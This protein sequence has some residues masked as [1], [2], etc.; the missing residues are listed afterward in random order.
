MT[1][2]VR[3]RNKG[4]QSGTGMLWYRTEIQDAG[5]LMPAASTLMPMPSYAFE[6]LNVKIKMYGIQI[7]IDTIALALLMHHSSKY[8]KPICYKLQEC[9]SGSRSMEIYQNCQVNL[10][11]CLSKM[12]LYLPRNLVEYIDRIKNDFKNLVLQALETIRIWFLQKSI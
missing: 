2:P 3:Y 12:L 4:S 1:E 5:M 9:G 8:L 11:S 7:F 10:S 6:A